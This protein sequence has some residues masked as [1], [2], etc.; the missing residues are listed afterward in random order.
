MEIS[1]EITKEIEKAQLE[2]QRL[3]NGK[4]RK[5]TSE[6]IRYHEGYIH[7][8]KKVAKIIELL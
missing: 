2:I 5:R 8:L 6:F 4:K 3:K 1:N 7:G